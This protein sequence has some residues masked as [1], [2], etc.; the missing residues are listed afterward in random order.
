[1]TG[2]W[3]RK[4]G[5][6]RFLGSSSCLQMRHARFLEGERLLFGFSSSSDSSNSRTVGKNEGATLLV[7]YP[8]RKAFSRTIHA[9]SWQRKEKE[10]KKG[11]GGAAVGWRTAERACR[12][13]IVHPVRHRLLARLRYFV[14]IHGTLLSA[15]WQAEIDVRDRG[16]Q[17]Q[18][19]KVECVPRE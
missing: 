18:A 14:W 16:R 13:Y 4:R 1:M 7:L 12:L 10:G 15:E 6:Q 17:L 3:R 8:Q 11:K 2:L 19:G 5:T 9:W